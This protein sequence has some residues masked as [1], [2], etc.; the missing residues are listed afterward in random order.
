[1][2]NMFENKYEKML[3]EKEQENREM[4]TRLMKII[5]KYGIRIPNNAEKNK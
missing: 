2:E 1:M 5:R 4:L 3:E